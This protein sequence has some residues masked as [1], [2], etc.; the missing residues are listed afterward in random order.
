MDVVYERAQKRTYLVML[1]QVGIYLPLLIGLFL[2]YPWL[3]GSHK[4]DYSQGNEEEEENETTGLIQ[5]D[6]E[7][8]TYFSS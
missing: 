5:T 1:I 2:L 4:I 8:W 3:A 6:S 7:P